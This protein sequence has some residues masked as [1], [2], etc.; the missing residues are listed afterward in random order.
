[1]QERQNERN[2]R[3][4]PRYRYDINI[5][6]TYPNE[7]NIF[8]S[9]D[10]LKRPLVQFKNFALESFSDSWIHIS[11]VISGDNSFSFLV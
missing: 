3:V 10:W 5:V 8:I 11:S 4:S 2:I 7:S 6:D 9:K 1:M